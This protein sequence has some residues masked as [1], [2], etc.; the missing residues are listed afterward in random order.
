MAKR[1]KEDWEILNKEL[2]GVPLRRHD[3]SAV[4][5]NDTEFYNVLLREIQDIRRSSRGAFVFFE[6]SYVSIRLKIHSFQS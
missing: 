2:H 5:G 4:A 3:L 6:A 1:G